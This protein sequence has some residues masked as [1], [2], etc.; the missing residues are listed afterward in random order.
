MSVS[1]TKY[2][3]F[4]SQTIYAPIITLAASKGCTLTIQEICNAVDSSVQHGQNQQQTA[5]QQFSLGNQNR[6][7]IPQ[8]ISNFPVAVPGGKPAKSATDKPCQ[9]K[10][11]SGPKKGQQCDR[12]AKDGDFCGIH[13]KNKEKAASGGKAA[14]A[15]SAP[16]T[17]G[18]G[19]MTLGQNPMFGQMQQQIQKPQQSNYTLDVKKK[20]IDNQEWYVDNVDNK[21]FNKLNDAITCYGVCVAEKLADGTFKDVI[22][23]ELREDDIQK[24]GGIN[25]KVDNTVKRLPSAVQQSFAP[26]QNSLFQMPNQQQTMTPMQSTQLQ[27]LGSNPSFQLGQQPQMNLQFQP[28]QSVPFQLG[29]AS[30]FQTASL[31]FSAPSSFASV[32]GTTAE[33]GDGDGEDEEGSD[34]EDGDAD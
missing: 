9:G 6:Q 15:F 3:E 8:G 7:F 21:V 11:N 32:S 23:R 2:L 34:N 29:Q 1:Y 27:P 13:T 28:S 33:D 5:T 20:M 30:G 19:A 16:L 4:V 31:P 14:N 18:M 12:A 25:V 17:L 22:V 24:L 10:F 26:Q